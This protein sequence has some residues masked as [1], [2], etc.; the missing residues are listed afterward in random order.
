MA[1][2]KMMQKVVKSLFVEGP[3]MFLEKAWK[4]LKLGFYYL[5][6]PPERPAGV[7]VLQY[8]PLISV[9][10][11]VYNVEP[12]IL[13]ACIDSV[14]NQ[15]YENWQLC[16]VDDHSPMKEMAEILQEYA[17]KDSRIAIALR[18]ENGHIAKA[19]NDAIA[20]CQGEFIAFM[21]CDDVLHKDALHEVAAL[22]NQDKQLDFIYTD[23][24]KLTDDGKAHYEPFFKPDWSPDTLLSMMYTG[25][26]GVYRTSLVNQAGGIHEGVNGSQDY[27]FTL[28]FTELT[29]RVG[30]VPRVLYHWRVRRESVASS[31]LA[32]PYAYDA[33]DKAKKDALA[34]RGISGH[35]EKVEGMTHQRVVYDVIGQPLV[36]VV[37]AKRTGSGYLYENTSYA[38]VQWLTHEEEILAQIQGEYIVFI[39]DNLKPQRAD[40][41]QG[42]L[43]QAQQIHT[44]V[45]SA[46]ILKKNKP[47]LL[48]Q[49]LTLTQDRLGALLRNRLDTLICY[50]GWNR[51]DVNCLAVTPSLM[52]VSTKKLK[53]AEASH[54]N[55]C[56]KLYALGYFN[57]LRNDV[58]FTC[59]QLP[60]YV[61][62]VQADRD[63]FYNP[64]LYKKW[65]DFSFIA[66]RKYL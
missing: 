50:V 18:Q 4:C 20:L 41:L 5:L 15:R 1:I 64:N 44:G 59:D 46:K 55:L 14:L 56:L 39:D 38:N 7:K 17:A 2:G 19:T 60:L 35:T 21:D 48:H 34:R 37:V 28:R 32:K 45:V 43:G 22:L 65:G 9:A 16:M 23:E 31:P 33:A 66:P 58:V 36:T 27:D 63:P 61:G 25:H 24:D 6:P 29:N 49:G 40:W 42:L 51:V 10:I 12:V 11:P 52:M 30:H 3:T 8:K 13:R 62:P 53:E 57:C 47:R 26:L 54:E